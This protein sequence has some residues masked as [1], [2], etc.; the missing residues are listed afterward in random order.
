MRRDAIRTRIRAVGAVA[1]AAV[2]VGG[3]SGISSPK[4]SQASNAGAAPSATSAAPTIAQELALLPDNGSDS[5]SI[6]FGAPAAMAAIDRASMSGNAAPSAPAPFEDF[7]SLSDPLLEVAD[8]QHEAHEVDQLGFD[9]FKSRYAV[10]VAS[11]SQTVTLV[12]GTFDPSAVGAK[13]SA[14]GFTRRDGG[15]DAIWTYKSVGTSQ[16]DNPTGDPTANVIDVSATRLIAGND[17]ALIQGLASNAKSLATEAVPKEL[18]GC[19]GSATTGVIGALPDPTG[20]KELPA[21]AMG[22]TAT[23]PTS[24][25]ATVCVAATDEKSAATMKA[26]WTDQLANAEVPGKNVPWS[27]VL[28][29]P[30]ATQY[31]SAGD[32][33]RLTATLAKS[34]SSAVTFLGTYIGGD[35]TALLVPGV[36]AS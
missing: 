17:V 30:E 20:G 24:M 18:A 4:T 3:C 34:D 26:R 11:G 6:L 13:L 19:L 10:T 15:G 27:E 12:F 31:S 23:S 22:I 16:A 33:I 29:S 5:G 1:A 32:V 9:P 7:Y 14:A 21:A 28:T 8:L 36:G 35:I 2:L 25:T